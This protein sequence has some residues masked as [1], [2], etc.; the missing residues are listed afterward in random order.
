MLGCYN[1]IY[2]MKT[3]LLTKDQ[4]AIV[5]DTDYEYLNQWKWRVH[6]NRRALEIVRNQKYSKGKYGLIY[7]SRFILGLKFGDKRQG[8]H[9]N[10]NIFD[11]RRSNLRICTQAENKVNIS[12][13]FDSTSKFLGVNWDKQT[14]NGEQEYV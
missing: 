12:S 14:V 1:L 9:I 3:I 8:D 11:N 4:Y 5:D 6:K 2:K 10:H 7:M 13:H